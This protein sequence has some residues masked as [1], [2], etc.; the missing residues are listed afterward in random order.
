VVGE[1]PEPQEAAGT[2]TVVIIDVVPGVGLNQAGAPDSLIHWDVGE[3]AFTGERGNFEIPML[4][5]TYT[6]APDMSKV[7]LKVRRGVQF[8]KGWGEMTAED[9]A[10]SLNDANSFTTPTSI[11]GQAGD[12]AALFGEAKVIDQYTVEIPFTGFDVRWIG[13]FLNYAS[14]PFA[15]LSKKA[16]DEKGE[17]WM[18]ENIIGTGPFQVVEWIRDDRAV[19]EALPNHWRKAAA[20][21]QLRFLEIPEES[22][23]IAFMRTGEAAAGQLALKSVPDL[24]KEGFVVFSGTGMGRK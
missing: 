5:E 1:A 11:H 23:R 7:T 20:V 6:L 17:D 14:N 13:N 21:K 19:L 16:Y 3:T 15:V 4:V 22:A 8:H 24:A 2:I 18:R 12:Y 10:W 9:F